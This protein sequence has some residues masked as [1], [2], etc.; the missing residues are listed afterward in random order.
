MGLD[1]GWD[2]EK[3]F[4]LLGSQDCLLLFFGLIISRG[5]CLSYCPFGVALHVGKIPV[6]LAWRKSSIRLITYT[7][8]VLKAHTNW[9]LH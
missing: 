4:I 7:F 5:D 8:G 2:P 6:N 3:F 1:S 9:L